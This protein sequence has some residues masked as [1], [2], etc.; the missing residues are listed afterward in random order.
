[1]VDLDRSINDYLGDTK[2]QSRLGKESEATVRRVIQHTA[3]LPGYY[4]TYYSDEPD[5]P[6][7]LDL[8]IRR[9]GMLMLPPGEKFYYSNLGYAVLGGGIAHVSGKSFADFL[10]GEVFLP[11]GMDHSSVLGQDRGGRRQDLDRPRAI[12]YLADGKRLPDYTTPH[13]PASDICASA[14]DLARFGLFHLK[15]HLSDQKPILSD[16]AIAEM[17]QATVPMGKDAYGLGWHIRKDAK[18]RR[19]VLHGGASAG[20]DAQFTLVPDEKLCVV[21]LANMTRHFP[22]AVTEHITNVI[23]AN[24]LGGEPEHFPIFRTDSQAKVSG[25]PESLRGKW[26]GI[27][28]THEREM[29]LVLSCRANGE[30]DAQLGDQSKKAVTDVRFES[31]VLTGKMAGTVGTRDA[32]RR[33]HDLEWELTLR[34]EVMNG[35]LYAVGRQGARGLRLGYWVELH[36]DK[37]AD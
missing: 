22:G 24:I 20:V 25:L 30:V 27:V 28:Q 35:T 10:H 17:Q 13:A 33:P 36:R 31:G 15:A 2:L 3:G 23:L 18:G 14:H 4:E 1:M 32:N 37:S 29:P 19:Y 6:P 5:K 11:L 16:K 21:V 7:A 8:V 9:Y 26:T 34:G 12:R